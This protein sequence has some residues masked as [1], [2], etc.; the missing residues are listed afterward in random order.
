LADRNSITCL[1]QD[2]GDTRRLGATIAGCLH[3]GTLIAL[4]GTLG[5][6]KTSLVRAMA[7]ALGVD[8]K[9]VV[10]P[11]F[12]MI[13]VYPGRLPIVHIDAYRIGDEDEFL[14]L[15]I[16][17]YL[18]DESVVVAM[19]WADRFADLLPADHLQIE[20]EVLGETGRRFSISWPDRP[21]PDR[22]TGLAILR[23]LAQTG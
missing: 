21:G 3:A 19:E 1:S 10:S 20:I 9:T 15:G 8:P 23:E 5:A 11:T 12:T 7:A 13:Q 14:E 6:G 18:D 2:D 22:Q 4:Q 16:H 17:E